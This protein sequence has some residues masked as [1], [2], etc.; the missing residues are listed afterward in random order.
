MRVYP[1]H[2]KSQSVWHVCSKLLLV[3]FPSNCDDCTWD[4]WWRMCD[5]ILKS[6][7]AIRAFDIMLLVL[8]DMQNANGKRKMFAP[9]LLT[10]LYRSKGRDFPFPSGEMGRRAMGN[11][12]PQMETFGVFQLASTGDAEADSRLLVVIFLNDINIGWVC[13]TKL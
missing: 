9:W 1:S 13:R 4:K 2:L 12:T 10:S 8:Q 3:T 5:N 11:L 6:C 7:E